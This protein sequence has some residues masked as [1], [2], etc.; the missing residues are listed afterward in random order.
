MIKPLNSISNH[1]F[2]KLSGLILYL[3]FSFQ[4]IKAQ[5]P[6]IKLQANLK[7]YIQEYSEEAVK[8]MIEFR[9]PASVILAQAIFESGSGTSDLAIKSNNHFGIKCHEEWIGD[10]ITK[11]DDTLNECFR[12]YVKVRDS[13]TDHSLFLSTRAR[14][15]YLFELPLT[16]YAGWCYGLKNAGYATY[17]TYAEDLIK[18][19]EDEKLYELD[20]CVK[21]ERKT[22]VKSSLAFPDKLLCTSLCSNSFSLKDFSK[23]GILWLDE[24]DVLIQSLEMLIDG[25]DTEELAV[26]AEK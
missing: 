21:L 15:A 19:I 18:L 6:Q 24:K 22:L 23:D 13:Y 9:I 1:V 3:V 12:K 4:I 16:D 2:L 10:T 14:Y 26:A 20:N 8:Q 11:T 7:P 25:S 17:P 5:P